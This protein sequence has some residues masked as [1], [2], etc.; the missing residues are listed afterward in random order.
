VNIEALETE[1]QSAAMS[2]EQIFPARARI[3]L[4]ASTNVDALGPS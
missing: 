4:Q 3:R 1:V 2:G